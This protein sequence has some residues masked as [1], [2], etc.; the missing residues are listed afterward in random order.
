MTKAHT[1]TL[2]HYNPD[3]H[4]TGNNT[5]RVCKHTLADTKTYILGLSGHVGG[6]TSL[7]SYMGDT[8]FKI[9]HAHLRAIPS[10]LHSPPSTA[11]HHTPNSI[12]HSLLLPWQLHF[13]E[14]SSPGLYTINS[15]MD[16]AMYMTD[17]GTQ[18]LLRCKQQDCNMFVFRHLGMIYIIIVLSGQKLT[19]NYKSAC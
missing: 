10:P 9:P 18:C 14:A 12:S 17:T 6:A 3:Q 13:P 5:G 4:I 15:L 7:D 11:S 16:T 19:S 2:P 1:C 8:Y